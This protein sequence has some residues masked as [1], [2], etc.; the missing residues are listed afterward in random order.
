[1]DMWGFPVP[2]NYGRILLAVS[3][4]AFP[5]GALVL[6]MPCQDE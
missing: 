5:A 1:M 3:R 6:H 2:I 4:Q